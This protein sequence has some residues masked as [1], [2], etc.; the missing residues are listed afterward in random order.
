MEELCKLPKGQQIELHQHDL[1]LL[2]P[3]QSPKEN[4]TSILHSQ[5]TAGMMDA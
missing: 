5:Y 2:C 4:I 3:Q 1:F